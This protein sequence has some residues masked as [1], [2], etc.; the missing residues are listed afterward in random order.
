MALRVRG[1][2]AQVNAGLAEMEEA[3]LGVQEVGRNT[4]LEE[5]GCCTA[6][7]ASAMWGAG[8]QMP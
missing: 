8:L 7:L 4:P 3:G 5:A 6:P 2:Q 1:L